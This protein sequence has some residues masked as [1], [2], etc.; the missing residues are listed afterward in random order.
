MIILY[1]SVVEMHSW[2]GKK[3]DWA[4]NWSQ[5]LATTA[6]IYVPNI[7][8]PMTIDQT[9]KK[10][11]IWMYTANVYRDLQGFCGFF[12]AITAGKTL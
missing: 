8:H 6:Q 3:D 1:R 2:C 11:N 12:S 5:F 7:F 10:P 9:F 4:E